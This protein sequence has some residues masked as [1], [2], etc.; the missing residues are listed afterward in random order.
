L[1]GSDRQ[2]VEDGATAIAR[3]DRREGA[4]HRQGAPE[5]RREFEADGIEIPR[6]E[7]L[8]GADASIVDHHV[9]VCGSGGD[10]EY[11]RVVGDVEVGRHDARVASGNGL[12]SP[13]GGI[14]LGGASLDQLADELRTQSSVGAGHQG[15]RVS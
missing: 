3:Q 4:R 2:D 5:M 7:V 8:H 15:R 11:G 6:D 14:D 9:D 1:E 13:R 10:V 12:R